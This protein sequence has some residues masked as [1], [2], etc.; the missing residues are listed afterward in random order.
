MIGMASNRQTIRLV[1]LDID[2]TLMCNGHI[3]TSNRQAIAQAQRAGVT[4]VLATVRLPGTA[5]AVATELDI[6]GPIICGIGA[7]AQDRPGGSELWHVRIPLEF[8]Q[9][10]AMYADS[11]DYELCTTVDNITYFRQR[12]AQPLGQ[13]T[14]DRCIVENNLRP[15]TSA[16]TRILAYGQA[17]VSI[18]AL[19]RE[20]YRQQVTFRVDY[21][22]G[23]PYALTMVSGQ[24]N[25][26]WA[27]ARICN[28]LGI[29]TNE[30]L[31]MGDSEPDIDMFRLPG[32]L[33]VAVQGA[34]DNVRREA[35][36]QSPP[37]EAGAVAWAL[38]SFVI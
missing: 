31:A 8:A 20:S 15:I 1:A 28:R 4:V 6:Q 9:Q 32:V 21:A 23:Q 36:V 26:G 34:P 7:I 19:F 24:A 25:K 30:V 14:E 37:C 18:D 13:W 29:P 27:L 2:G 3:A 16:P 5:L 33:S 22:Q 12:P 17:A 11:Q 10:L 35:Q 38:N